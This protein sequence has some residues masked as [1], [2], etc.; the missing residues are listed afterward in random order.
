MSLQTDRQLL[1]TAASTVDGVEVAANYRGS[2][3]VGNGLVRLDRMTR[4]ENGFG[5]MNTWQVVVFMPADAA[6]AEA[7]L[8]AKVGPLVA[9]LEPHMTIETITPAQLKLTTGTSPVV[10]IQGTREQ[11]ETP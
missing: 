8:D 1:A 11:E 3:T 4:S 9:A 2:T 10:F 5:Y 6:A 7:Y